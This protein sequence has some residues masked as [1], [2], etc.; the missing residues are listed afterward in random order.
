MADGF[1][2]IAQAAQKDELV[3]KEHSKVGVVGGGPSGTLFAYFLLKLSKRLGL[4]LEVDIYE[5][6]DFT[7]HGPKGC[8]HCGGIVSESLVQL[9]A[10]EGINIPETVLQRGIETYT[11][12]TDNGSGVINTPLQEKRIAAIF[13]GG[14]PLFRNMNKDITE[15]LA[16]LQG[17]DGFLLECAVKQGANVINDRVTNIIKKDNFPEVTTHGG[18]IKIYDLLVGAVGLNETTMKLFSD[19]MSGYTLPETTRTYIAEFYLG[20]EQISRYFGNSMH[21]FLINIPRLKF[22]AFVPKG[23][24]I[25]MVLLGSEID[26]GLVDTFLQTKEVRECFPSDFNPLHADNCKCIPKINISKAAHPYCDRML[27]VGDSSVARLYKDGIGSAYRVSKAA[28]NAAVLN[29]ISKADFKKYFL[30]ECIAIDNDNR[31]GKVIFLITGLIQKF[32]FLKRG[33][34]F[35]VNY[36]QKN[37]EKEPIMSTVL[38]D[39]FT[40]SSSYKDILVRFF[41][42]KFTIRL[43]F[44]FIKGIFF[45]VS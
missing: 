15:K 30:P 14:G 28:A 3:L 42:L 34:L 4:N 1:L 22:A 45:K 17:L 35:M 44:Y 31:I 19:K 10:T 2:K 43:I 40:G 26:Q 16:Q 23:D 39:T 12:H 33:I 29:G 38:W 13:R 6:K 27:V 37:R 25:T 32:F 20:Q 9:L 18:N 11:M 7:C 24:F 21:V 36:E 8:N 5:P 41:N